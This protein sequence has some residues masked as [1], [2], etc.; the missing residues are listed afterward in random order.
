MKTAHPLLP[1]A[2]IAV[3]SLAG[4]VAG[5]AGDGWHDLAA[6]C[7]LAASLAPLAWALRRR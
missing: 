2:V 7:G 3:V 6:A 5:L 1:I 4:M